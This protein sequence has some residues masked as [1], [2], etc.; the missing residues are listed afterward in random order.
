MRVHETRMANKPAEVWDSYAQDGSS[1]GVFGKVSC[2]P[3][4]SQPMFKGE[5]MIPQ[6]MQSRQ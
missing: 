2:P 4:N 1:Y 6:K 5:T 3:L